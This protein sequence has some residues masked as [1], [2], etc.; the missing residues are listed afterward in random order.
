ML[1]F[2]WKNSIEQHSAAVRYF[3]GAYQMPT[4]LDVQNFAKNQTNQQQ[5]NFIKYASQFPVTLFEILNE[6][7]RAILSLVSCDE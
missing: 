6:I 3:L 2:L 5:T 7:K 4:T 1:I